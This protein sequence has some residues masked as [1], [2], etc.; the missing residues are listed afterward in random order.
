MPLST[1]LE[2]LR[3]SE[4][5]TRENHKLI[6]RREHIFPD[7]LK[8]FRAGFNWKMPISILFLGEPVID[9]GGPSREYFRLLIGDMCKSSF[10]EGAEDARV[11]THNM[12]ALEKQTYKHM[13]KLAL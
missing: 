6:V 12:V 8:A 11:P 4:L 13:G 3:E 5:E 10:F 7:S 9:A 1:L 2:N